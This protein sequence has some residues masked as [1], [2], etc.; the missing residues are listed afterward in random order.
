MKSFLS[1][2]IM[3]KSFLPRFKHIFFYIFI[4]LYNL[5][6]IEPIEPIYIYPYEIFLYFLVSSVSTGVVL[7]IC[8]WIRF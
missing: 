8:A 5:T 3:F 4:N 1:F 7:K 6:N 2:P